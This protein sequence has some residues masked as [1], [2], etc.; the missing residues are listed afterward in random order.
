M[1]TEFCFSISASGFRAHTDTP[2]ASFKFR[3]KWDPFLGLNSNGPLEGD[4]LVIFGLE[5]QT[6]KDAPTAELGHSE[7]NI[8]S[9]V[10]H[11]QK[12][13]HH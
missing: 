11:I 2:T 6:S 8:L 9:S 3:N 12:A 10:K 4:S 7:Y 13:F 1:Q 5:A